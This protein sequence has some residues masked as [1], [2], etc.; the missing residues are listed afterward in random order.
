[1][2]RIVI[3]S[4]SDSM[5]EQ[6]S[7]LLAS[8]GHTLFRTCTSESELRRALDACEDGVAV[9]AGMLP[10]LHVDNLAWDYGPQIQILMIARPEVLNRVDAENIFRLPVPASGQSILGALEM[11]TQLHGM[12]MPRRRGSEK[13][14]VEAAKRILMK[15]E[16]IPE[17]VAHRKM[18][19]YAMNHG[20]KMSEYAA[21]ILSSAGK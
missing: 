9:L 17:G 14:T 20:M 16:G 5:L 21:Q 4:A 11:L 1:M 6:L 3:A 18:Q 2:A 19:Q 15:R 13:E 8:S 10:G 12:N 7:R